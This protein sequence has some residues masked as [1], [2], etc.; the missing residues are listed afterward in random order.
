VNL[1]WATQAARRR[2]TPN[3]P[4]C[5]ARRGRSRG[6]SVPKVLLVSGIFNTEEEEGRRDRRGCHNDPDP[7]AG[8]PQCCN[9]D[10]CCR[11]PNPAATHQHG[12]TETG[13][14]LRSLRPSSASVINTPAANQHLRHEVRTSPAGPAPSSREPR[15]EPSGQCANPRASV[16]RCPAARP[17]YPAAPGARSLAHGNDP[18]HQ[19]R[20]RSDDA[21]AGEAAH[22]AADDTPTTL[23]VRPCLKLG[24]P[25]TRSG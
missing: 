18:M 1:R 25:V 20:H 7:C 24:Q 12:S 11:E 8:K 14:S 9:P 5:G 13:P 2:S 3:S 19:G 4:R 10:Q 15:P 21:A 23:G 16:T 17:A 6:E 22:H